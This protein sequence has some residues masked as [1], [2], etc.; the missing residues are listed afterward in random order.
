VREWGYWKKADHATRSDGDKAA[1]LK[2]TWSEW[3]RRE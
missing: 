1:V 3:E 2:E